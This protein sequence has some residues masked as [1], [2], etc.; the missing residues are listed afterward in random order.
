MSKR[1]IILEVR[2][3]IEFARSQAELN[4]SKGTEA[5]N[6]NVYIYMIIK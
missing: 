2:S 6:K 1:G 4:S 5:R 3:E